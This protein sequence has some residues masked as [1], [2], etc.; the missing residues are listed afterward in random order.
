MIKTPIEKARII[1]NEFSDYI[2]S[3]FILKNEK[4]NNDFRK[5]LEDAVLSR[6]PFLK[7]E[8]PFVKA[9]TINELIDEEVLS[10]RF[11][12]LHNIKPERNLYYHQEE[13]IR[14]S[15]N[16]QNIV[17]TTGTGSGKTEGFLFPIINDMFKKLD[18]GNSIDGIHTIILYPMNALVNDQLDRLREMLKNTPEITFGHFTGDT[19]HSYSNNNPKY[20]REDYIRENFTKDDVKPPSNELLTRDEIRNTP[21]NIL[22]TNFSM[23]EYL[24][25]RPKDSTVL[26]AKTLKD[27]SYMVLDEAH[28]YRGTLA[29]EVSHLLKR[30]KAYTN[31]NPNFILTS[32]TLGTEEKDKKDIITFADNLTSNLF[33]NDGIIFAK[34][35]YPGKYKVD[36][37]L[38]YLDYEFINNNFNNKNKLKTII[39]K[40]K[41]NTLFDLISHDNN[42]HD[43]FRYAKDT[44]TYDNVYN[45][46]KKFK[47]RILTEEEFNKFINVITSVKDEFNSP[48][49]DIKY[50]MFLRTLEGAFVSLE[51]N[52]KLKI[53]NRN[54]IE[55][56]K[57]FEIGSCK[58]C[59]NIYLMG[60]TRDSK[61]EKKKLD[62]EENYQ[63]YENMIVEYYL[64][65]KENLEIDLTDKNISEYILCS[66]CGEINNS[67]GKLGCNCGD[68]Y[69][70]EV[71]KVEN[72]KDSKMTNNLTSCP[73]CN[74]TSNKYGI[75][76][77]FTLGKDQSTAVISQIILKSMDKEK[78]EK[79]NKNVND[80]FKMPD[81][82]IK[83][84]HIK[85]F[86]AFSDSRQQASFYAL[87]FQMMQNKFLR[88]RL[89]YE[90]AQTGSIDLLVSNLER[91]IKDKNL[92]NNLSNHLS[93]TKNAYI[94]VLLELLKSDGVNSLE[95]LG[96][97][98]FRL[99]ID[100]VFEKVTK[101]QIESSLFP[102]K[103]DELES[104]IN[105]VT[106]VFRTTPAIEYNNSGLNY[107]EKKDFLEYRS[108]DNYIILNKSRGSSNKYS[109]SLI[110]INT[111]TYNNI[112]SY[113]N[114]VYKLDRE[115]IEKL[116]ES[117]IA[118]MINFK[119]IVSDDN[120]N[121]QIPFSKYKVIRGEEIKWYMCNKC[122]DITPYN[123]KG[124]CVKGNCDGE[125]EEKD[126]TIE[127]RDNYYRKEYL[128]KTIENIV[129]EEH[130]GQLTRKQGKDYQVRFKNKEINVL[131]SSTTFEMGIDIGS[132][133][134]V[135]MRNIPPT[136]ANYAQRAGRAG[137]SVDSEAFILTFAN[138][139][140]H[141]QIYFKN[142]I[143]MIEGRIDPPVFK[144]NN[145]KI[146][147]RHIFAYLISL[148]YRE[149]N[150]GDTV[151]DFI[152]SGYKL[153]LEY[154]NDN[155]E[156]LEPK[157]LN[158]LHKESIN[159]FKNY[160]WLKEIDGKDKAVE[161]FK[162]SIEQ[163]IKDIQKLMKE[164]E[165]KKEY[166]RL[167]NLEKELKNISEMSIVEAFSKYNVIP[168]YSFP[169]NVVPLK[170]YD[171]Q[172]NRFNTS[173]N[174]NRDLGQAISEYA[175]DSE[176]IANKK[177]YTSRYIILPKEGELKKHYY[178][179]CQNERCGYV[180]TSRIEYEDKTCMK[181]NSYVESKVFIE[182]DLGF[183]TD[184]DKKSSEQIRP[185][186]TYASEIKYLGDP[187]KNN[188][189]D[190]KPIIINQSENERLLIVNENPF[191]I[192]ESC[193]YTEL[194]KKSS[195]L[196]TKYQEHKRHDGIYMS[197][198]NTRLDNH[199]LGH[200][201][202][203]DVIK[204]R[205]KEVMS[206]SQ[207][208][209][210]LTALINGITSELQIDFNDIN[211]TLVRDGLSY[212][213]IVYDTTYGGSGNVK[214]LLD[215]AKL[216][217]IL[218]ISLS[219]VSND[220][221][222]EDVSCTNCLRNYRNDRRH[223]IL[224]RGE[225]KKIIG[226]IV[227][228]L[229]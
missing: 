214:Q 11:I 154:I 66:K 132:L 134:T 91:V 88:K 77:S 170:V 142:P 208:Y 115:E 75:V 178:Y 26:N 194:D 183:I 207:A 135:F 40:Y 175:P 9:K 84:N 67:T 220:C 108:F 140:S 97:I 100:D 147:I 197:C 167:N 112:E 103:A 79:V 177:K 151:N 38:S 199:A 86:L 71:Y 68:V 193:G 105:I 37:Q 125:L 141:D 222:S 123:I 176:V 87:F 39:E 156:D 47:D 206:F 114:K 95:G 34:R 164:L 36:H 162:Q 45:K 209:S 189:E 44:D 1:E 180:E 111:S 93:E 161:K 83:D 107:E 65:K 4:Y 185:K 85:Q 229:N 157:V 69:I 33:N 102:V 213:F 51:P 101:E 216:L 62:I 90:N 205:L 192:C 14:Q 124:C 215:D 149:N 218:K 219:S 119:L 15:L 116:L 200:I 217:K 61:L 203:T 29:T 159:S 187:F 64:L 31:S 53:T 212:A 138:Q 188:I 5:E 52:P 201:I 94:S 198:T 2:K 130:T 16:N 54:E 104:L 202:T 42:V 58:N 168:G 92:L 228:L 70:N 155:K 174:L 153:F 10:S 6:G 122:K 227:E 139:K 136:N 186:K 129:V 165:G 76:Q 110:S 19:P 48:I 106:D 73:S 133:D 43:L 182:P 226:N 24:Q 224:I 127:L 221:C 30:L 204:I 145:D 72:N 3:T 63:G 211:G 8:L 196:K 21:P 171:Y 82:I 32:A 179:E 7:L 152:H 55:G 181:C 99:S 35:I 20:T 59:N 113:L 166:Y 191:F 13:S 184:E 144:L 28:F 17:L 96:L 126:L 25:I 81:P 74:K 163:E 172:N 160:Q 27:W 89:V 98:N 57:A 109:R 50:H 18:S 137:R 80:I 121:L 117:I 23:L 12:K 60:Q 128:T 41:K 146:S 158:I 56:M 169:I 173:M 210:T 150:I 78:V 22:I 120:I 118:L 223:E 148:F 143:P 46:I 49:F 195:F 190:N 131:S 225:A